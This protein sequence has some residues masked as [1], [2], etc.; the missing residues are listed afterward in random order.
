MKHFR[1]IFHV[2]NVIGLGLASIIT[3]ICVKWLDGFSLHPDRAKLAD[4]NVHLVCTVTGLV[5]APAY[6]KK[7]K[8]EWL[9]NKYNIQISGS[10]V[11]MLIFRI[12]PHAAF[13]RLVLCHIVVLMLM[14]FLASFGVKIAYDSHHVYG[15]KHLYS[16]HGWVGVTIS[17]LLFFLVG[18]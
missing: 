15:P 3:Y 5:L 9:L 7:Y 4:Y 17:A 16:L 14:S 6:G 18:I 12:F 8:L 13:S 10:F 2:V 11:G 1:I